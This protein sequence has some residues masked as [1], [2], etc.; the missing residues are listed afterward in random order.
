MQTIEYESLLKNDVS[1]S[2][3]KKKNCIVAK[4]QLKICSVNAAYMVHCTI[5]HMQFLNILHDCLW[6]HKEYFVSLNCFFC[7]WAKGKSHKSKAS[8]RSTI[9]LHYKLKSCHLEGNTALIDFQVKGPLS[10]EN[11][12]GFQGVVLLLLKWSWKSAN[13]AL[14]STQKRR[15][16]PM[17]KAAFLFPD[18]SCH[19][20][21]WFGSFFYCQIDGAKQKQRSVYYTCS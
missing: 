4:L 16:R 10:H 21:K 18:C 7:V 13:L 3:K 15:T 5:L 9:H 8:G 6:W 20:S 14:T 17:G 1:R 19:H 2:S 11:F 12:N